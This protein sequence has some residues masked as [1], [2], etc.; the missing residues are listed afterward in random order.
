V[1]SNPLVTNIESSAFRTEHDSLGSAQEAKVLASQ[2]QQRL[3]DSV[4]AVSAS[5]ISVSSSAHEMQ[6]HAVAS[7]TT[8]A[9]LPAWILKWMGRERKADFALLGYAA[10]HGR[11]A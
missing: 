6:E 8:D 3:S 1:P 4:Q 10:V 11:T 2:Q 5:S 9:L 7:E